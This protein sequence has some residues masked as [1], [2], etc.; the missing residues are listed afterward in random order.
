MKFNIEMRTI[1]LRDH[2]ATD[3]SSLNFSS[4]YWSEGGKLTE[5]HEGLST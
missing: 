2:L 4:Y 1:Y 5:S 3:S